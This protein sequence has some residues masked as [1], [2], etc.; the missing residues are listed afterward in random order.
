MSSVIFKSL[1]S[2]K[3]PPQPAGLKGG[4]PAAEQHLDGLTFNLYLSILIESKRYLLQ[5]VL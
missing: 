2:T 1:V 3:R 4:V 5:Q